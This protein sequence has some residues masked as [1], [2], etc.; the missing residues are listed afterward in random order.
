ML[1]LRRLFLIFGLFAALPAFAD[2]LL[3][4][5]GAGYKRPLAELSA[6]F[7]KQSGIRVEQIYGNMGNI[8]AQVKQSGEIAVVFGDHAFLSKVEGIDFASYLA[9]GA[10][11]LVIAWPTGGKLADPGELAD[12]RFARIAVPN[13]KAAIYGIAAS[14][15]LA[16]SKLHAQVKDRLQVVATVPQVSAYL[17]SGEVDAGFINLTEALSIA[18][19]IGGYRE[20]D[21]ELYAPIRIVGGLLRPQAEKASVQALGRFLENPEARAILAKHGL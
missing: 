1:S 16:S 8:V 17:I 13:P 3:I 19:K 18:P 6:A 5:A 2:T 11:R 20:I 4:A 12:S 14:E 15:F 21:A 7:E 9:L 10:G